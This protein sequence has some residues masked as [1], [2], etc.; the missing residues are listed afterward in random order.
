MCPAQRTLDI[1][2]PIDRKEQ[3][4][5]E[6]RERLLLAAE[7]LYA[8]EG[9]GAVSMRRINTAANQKNVSALHYHFGTREAIMEAIFDYRM[10]QAGARRTELLEELF[11]AGLES[12][13][14]AL[15][16]VAI[17][18]LAEQLMAASQPNYFVRFLAQSHRLPQFDNWLEVRHRNRQSIVRVYVLIMRAITGMPRSIIHTRAVMALRHAIYTLAD[19]DRLIEERHSAKRDEMVE[20]Y[21]NDLIDIVTAELSAPMSSAT[22]RAYAA[23]QPY[24]GDGEVTLFG[25]DTLQA[26]QRSSARR[27]RSKR[28]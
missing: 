5:R 7:K 27:M 24:D 3:R 8:E 17:W 13:L 14:R 1:D 10:S 12:D 20:F 19:L 2:P 25:L 23:M 28:G 6:T 4:S 15:V 21:A 16:H 11:D 9:I 22:E 18:P 26:H